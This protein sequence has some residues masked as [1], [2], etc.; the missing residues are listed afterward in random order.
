MTVKKILETKRLV[1]REMTQADYDDLAKIL[2]DEKVMYAYKGAFSDAEVQAWLDNQRRRYQEDGFGLWAVEL[3]G[4]AEMIGQCGLTLQDYHDE[5]VIE[6]GYLFRKEFW[7]RGY[8]TEAA[9]ACREYA[10]IELGVPVVYSIIRDTNLASQEVAWRNGMS[11]QDTIVKHYR[12]YEMPHYV[13]AVQNLHE[14][15]AMKEKR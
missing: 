7:H 5:R 11:H 1:L 6:V 14:N 3:K 15:K 4:S 8:A 9:V 10:F 2:Q 13:Y 12:G